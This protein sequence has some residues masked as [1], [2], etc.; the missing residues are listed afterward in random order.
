MSYPRPV[1]K[2][3]CTQAELYAICIIGWKSYNDNLVDF[4]DFST[5][6]DAQFATD[7]L[8]A[9]QSAKELPDFQARNEPSETSHIQLVSTVLIC[10]RNWRKLRR[11]IVNAFAKDIVKGK[12]E[13]AGEEHYKKSI[14]S[15]WAETE[16]MLTSATTFITE[17]ATELTAGGM[18]AQFTTDFSTAKT[19]FLNLYGTFTGSEQDEV[20]GTDAKIIANNGIYD[21]LMVMFEDGQVIFEE[22]PAKRERFIFTRV[23]DLISSSATSGT[24]PVSPNTIEL[25]AYIFNAQTELPVQGA[26]LVVLNSPSGQPVQATTDENG[27]LKLTITGYQPDQVVTVQTQVTATNFETIEAEAQLGTGQLYSFEIPM[28][29]TPP[30][31]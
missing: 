5:K 2:Y 13:A 10:N 4:S 16:L 15:S 20:E 14:A 29:P 9:V 31:P 30:Q 22:N 23:K 19:N 27:I 18:P 7:A 1:R 24:T 8:Q 3:N 11:H 26:T 21:T 17:N 6:Y 28:D 25:A 12:I